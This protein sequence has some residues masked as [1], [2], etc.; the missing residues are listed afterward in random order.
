M[1]ATRFW[2]GPCLCLS[3]QAPVCFD[4]DSDA[5]EHM[6]KFTIIMSIYSIDTKHHDFHDGCSLFCLISDS[7]FSF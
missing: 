5:L 4:A 3:V 6:E 1:I 2:N 7:L